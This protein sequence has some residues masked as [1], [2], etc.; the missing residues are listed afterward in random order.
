MAINLR[1]ARLVLLSAVPAICGPAA[2][3]TLPRGDSGCIF[4]CAPAPAESGRN[5]GS[6]VAPDTGFSAPADSFLPAA[7]S[8]LP[9]AP[10]YDPDAGT[11]KRPAAEDLAPA[12]S[13]P[14]VA[15]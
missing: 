2:A 10:I 1:F 14:L 13:A 3:A 6:S 8:Y 9:S 5:P 11:P 15:Q 7:D 4:D 12:G